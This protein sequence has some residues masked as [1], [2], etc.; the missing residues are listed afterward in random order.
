MNK[1]GNPKNKKQAK[2]DAL[3]EGDSPIPVGALESPSK[4]ES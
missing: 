1:G 3:M 4:K 2:I